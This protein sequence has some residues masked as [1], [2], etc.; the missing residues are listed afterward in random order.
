MTELERLKKEA[1][2]LYL[3]AVDFDDLSCGRQLAEFLR[4]DVGLARA[5]F[6]ETWAKIRELDS[7]A[8]TNPFT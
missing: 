6:N 8:P 5:K 7:K 4:P 1:K 3:K 2:S